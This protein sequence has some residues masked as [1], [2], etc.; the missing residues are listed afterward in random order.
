M[1]FFLKLLTQQIPIL[2]LYDYITYEL[3]LLR[4]ADSCGKAFF[5]NMCAPHCTVQKEKSQLK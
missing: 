4:W 5:K 2:K 1:T 3:V